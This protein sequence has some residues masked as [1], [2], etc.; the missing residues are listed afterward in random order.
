MTIFRGLISHAVFSFWA[1][2][3]GLWPAS[4]VLHNPPTHRRAKCA[5]DQ[6]GKLQLRLDTISWEHSSGWSFVLALVP[7]ASPPCA[8]GLI[9]SRVQEGIKR[10][11]VF[12]G[13]LM[14]GLPLWVLIPGVGTHRDLE[15]FRDKL[16]K[17]CSCCLAQRHRISGSQL[18]QKAG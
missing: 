10:R 1:A 15:S 5:S 16:K 9:F 6:H 4:A 7:P 2:S 3:R 8:R 13:G 11:R 12:A 14:P 17:I 18:S